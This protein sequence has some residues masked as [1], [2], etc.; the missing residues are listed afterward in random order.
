MPRLHW[1]RLR[2][3]CLVGLSVIAFLWVVSELLGRILCMRFR[4]PRRRETA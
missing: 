2:D 1:A 4:L 3:Q